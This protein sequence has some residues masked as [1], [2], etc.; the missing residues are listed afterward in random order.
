M[1]STVFLYYLRINRAAKQLDQTK[2]KL[3]FLVNFSVYI[4]KN[5]QVVR[6]FV[7]ANPHTFPVL[8]DPR[9]EVFK[10][11]GVVPRPTTILIDS[12]GKIIDRWIGLPG[13]DVLQAAL[14]RAGVGNSQ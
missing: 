10:I 7:A 4:S 2:I 3:T 5:D 11:Y 6:D 1:K 9:G 13:S 8:L 14:T 12:A